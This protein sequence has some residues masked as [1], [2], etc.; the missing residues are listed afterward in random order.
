MGRRRWLSEELLSEELL[1][2]ELLYVAL[3]R[4]T[5]ELLSEELLSIALERL[6]EELLSI[7]L[8]RLTL[9]EVLLPG[10][11]SQAALPGSSR[12]SQADPLHLLLLCRGADKE[13]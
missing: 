5:E 6:T 11:H 9:I 2:E 8:E 10:A 13:L 3:E 1:S 7:A 4:L 12:E